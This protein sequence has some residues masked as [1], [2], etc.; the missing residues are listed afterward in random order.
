M[1]QLLFIILL[2]TVLF[3]SCED[4]FSQTVEVDPP[5]YSPVLV[6]HQTIADNEDSIRL[7]LTRNYGILDQVNNQSQWFVKGA[8]IEWWQNEQKKLTLLPLSVDS[9]FVY[10]GQ[11]PERLKAG[12][13][14]EIRISHPDFE[15]VTAAQ[16]MPYPISNIEDVKVTRNA[17]T[18][19]FGDSY[20]EVELSFKDL[21]G[22]KNYYEFF[23]TSIY[24]YLAQTGFEPDGTPIY[25]T[26][27]YPVAH[28]F[29]TTFDPNIKTGIGGS[30]LLTDQFFDGQTYK[31]KGQFIDYQNGETPNPLFLTIRSTTQ[32]Y[33]YWSKSYYQQSN[34][35]D[36][37]FAEPVTVYNNLENGLGIFGLFAERKFELK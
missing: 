3:A 35:G 27:Y 26:V 1:K 16:T 14:Y 20:S 12:E 9:A 13:P 28:Q 31:F 33:Y 6:F 25:D 8:T 17:G 11:L 29:E 24:S 21:G 4:F 34:S 7:V 22:E 19:E 36:N 23:L 5:D 15:P 37:P 2:S 30:T 10:V 18:N 32:D